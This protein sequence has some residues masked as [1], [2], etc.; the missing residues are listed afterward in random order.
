MDTLLVERKEIP[1]LVVAEAS[2][3]EHAAQKKNAPE[4]AALEALV[5]CATVNSAIEYTPERAACQIGLAAKANPGETERAAPRGATHLNSRE[6]STEADACQID[7]L[8]TLGEI[9][10]TIAAAAETRIVAAHKELTDTRARLGRERSARELALR[11]AQERTELAREALAGLANERTTLEE[12]ARAFLGGESLQLVLEKVH[13][14]FNLRQLELESTLA[15]A[16]AEVAEAQHEIEAASV[17]DALELQLAEQEL[18]RLES[19][20]P[21]VARQINLAATAAENLRA[22]RQAVDDGLLLDA[23]R[24]LAQAKEGQA[25]PAA[26]AEVERRLAAARDNQQVRDFI[27]RLNANPQ[28]PGAVRRIHQLM[29]EAQKAGVADKA[30]PFAKKALAVARQAANSRFAE[31]RPIADHLV[32]E[33]YVPVVGDGRIEAWKAVSRN[34]HGMVWTLDYI[35][36]LRGEAG[37]VTEIPRNPITRKE[38]PAKVRHS[39][40]YRVAGASPTD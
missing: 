28:A 40:W 34:G 1:P 26:L 22:A 18:E 25:E 13:L 2:E 9:E 36:S 16:Q 29:D 11:S 10:A 5:A 17:T 32:S 31:A 4:L 19:A 37:W 35:L 39:R 21:E 38:L 7:A 8:P 20:A 33:G 30:T 12:R 6:Y 14:A 3:D 15:G 24:L 23:D 27:A